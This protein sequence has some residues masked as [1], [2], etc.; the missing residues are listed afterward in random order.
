MKTKKLI[1]L[2]IFLRGDALDPEL[3]SSELLL[4]PSSSQKKGEIRKS[5]SG[6]Q[7]IT[8]IG[9][10]ELAATCNSESLSEHVEELTSK[11]T[12]TGSE[13]LAIEGVEEAYADLFIGVETDEE[14]DGTC[15]FQLT[16]ANLAALAKLGLPVRFT[17][18]FTK[19]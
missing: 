1:D 3:V 19:E 10:W 4:S 14:G 2:S 5:S 9:V 16:E 12:K 13:L 7:Y 8:Q 6:N 15:E 17:V 11:V 18:S